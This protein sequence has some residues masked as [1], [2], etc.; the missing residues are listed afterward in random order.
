MPVR[1]RL[2]H[3]KTKPLAKLHYALLMAGWAKMPALARKRQ[4]I[5]MPAISTSHP[6]K[7]IMQITAVQVTLDYSSNIRSEKTILSLKS[8]F[9]YLLK[10]F[11]V[12]FNALVVG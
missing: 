10:Y 4:Q 8:V 1:N 11:K 3:F 6:G 2:D 9:I 5:F 12:L 7:T